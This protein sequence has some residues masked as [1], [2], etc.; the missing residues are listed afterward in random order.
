MRNIL[1][2]ITLI[3]ILIS[4]CTVN[5][6]TMLPPIQPVDL[7]SEGDAAH[8]A[9]LFTKGAH[10]AP[11]CSSC[12][13]LGD[14]TFSLGPK[15]TGVYERAGRREPDLTAEAYLYESITEPGAYVVSGYR[16]IMYPHYAEKLSQQ[17][18]ADLIAYLMTL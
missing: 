7:V 3:A 9:E 5:L 14:S 18:I 16:D 12:H 17:E 10:E 2:S 1:I 4:G 11:P 15:L 8:G 6:W 13:T